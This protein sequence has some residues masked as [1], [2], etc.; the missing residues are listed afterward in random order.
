MLLTQLG[1]D[2]PNTCDCLNQN[3]VIMKCDFGVK[4]E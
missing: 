1:S 2:R 4:L 3:I